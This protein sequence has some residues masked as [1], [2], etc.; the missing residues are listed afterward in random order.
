MFVGQTIDDATGWLIALATLVVFLIIARFHE[1]VESARKRTL[2]LR[3]LYARHIARIDLDW[4]GLME[5]ASPVVSDHPF[6]SDLDILG[7]R[8]LLGLMSTAGTRGGHDRLRD[9]LLTTEADFESAST[10]QR[11]AP[12]PRSPAAPARP[13]GPAGASGVRAVLALG[14][15]TPN[16]GGGSGRLRRRRRCACGRGFWVDFRP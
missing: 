9:W 1:R 8:S 16:C 10:R 13:A 2:L 6:A 15:T 14:G 5:D 3:T 7:P 11:Q 4:S 12:R